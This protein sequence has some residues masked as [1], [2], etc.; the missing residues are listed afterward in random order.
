MP[1]KLDTCLKMVSINK[2]ECIG[3]GAC[4]SICPEGIEMK[5]MKAHVK[6]AKAKNMKE[7][8]DSCPVQAIKL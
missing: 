6:N 5:D 1:D 7:A 2:E 4:E 8:A 3:C